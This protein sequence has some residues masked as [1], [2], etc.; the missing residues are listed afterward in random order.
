MDYT[1]QGNKK[2]KNQGNNQSQ[3]MQVSKG[4]SFMDN[5]GT[6]SKL[7]L[8]GRKRM[9][10]EVEE[11]SRF[12]PVL[13]SPKE[14]S[15][16]LQFN[17]LIGIQ[18]FIK[19]PTNKEQPADNLLDDIKLVESE[20]D[21][22]IPKQSKRP[23]SQQ[24]NNSMKFASHIAKRQQVIELSCDDLLADQLPD[25]FDIDQVQKKKDD[26]CSLCTKALGFL[27]KPRHNC[28]NCGA[29]VCDKCSNQK[30]QLSKRDPTKY[31]VCNYCYTIKTNR[32]IILFYKEMD[33]AK[34]QS[35]QDLQNRKLM[36]KEMLLNDEKEI[37]NLKR[38][39][40][41]QEIEQQDQLE[42]LADQLNNLNNELKR[43]KD[44]NR[45]WE[46]MLG[47]EEQNA[48][49]KQQEITTL[50]QTK[51]ELEKEL[52]RVETKI[53]QITEEVNQF[54]YQ[55]MKLDKSQ[56]VQD[57]PKEIQ[58]ITFKYQDEKNNKERENKTKLKQQFLTQ[59]VNPI[60]EVSAEQDNTYLDSI[61]A[62]RNNSQNFEQIRNKDRKKK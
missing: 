41:E 52:L 2:I 27:K 3:S 30:I 5:V 61:D 42:K 22:Q 15:V 8:L 7:G 44:Q 20:Y 36:Y 58:R 38:A 55:L 34:K 28:Y 48:G 53:K 24:S 18:K 50:E 40:E 56:K 25:N 43:N 45:Q 32:Q 59:Q 49:K 33:N 46:A 11:I 6:N 10:K 51:R 62:R 57:Q 47:E 39:L 19:S 21:F 9:S 13:N 29:C 23:S 17:P 35:I 54:V 12:N 14:K 26:Y 60:I 16:K 31:R 4:S 1:D 37:R